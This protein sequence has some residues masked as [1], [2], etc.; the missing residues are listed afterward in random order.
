M[1][2]QHCCFL[3]VFV[4]SATVIRA[5]E[6]PSISAAELNEDVTI[7]VNALKEAHTGMYWYTPETVFNETEISIRQQI[8]ESNGQTALE[9]YNTIAPYV[10]LTKEDHCDISL[11]EETGSFLG[12][13]G[14]FFPFPVK[15]CGEK[16]YLIGTDIPETMPLNGYEL[17]AIDGNAMTGITAR[18]FTTFA[19][20]GNI[21]TSKY[22][23]LDDTGFSKL[24]AKTISWKPDHFDLLV[25][26]PGSEATQLVTVRS[27]TFAGLV[28]AFNTLENPLYAEKGPAEMTITPEYALLTIR[29]FSGSDYR[30][31]G[32]RF[33]GFIDSCFNALKKAGTQDLIIDVRAN[34][35][36][37]EGYEDYLFSYLATKPYNKYRYVETNALTYSFYE[38]TDY[39]DAK[40]RK[41]FERLLAK[42]FRYDARSGK[43]RRKKNIERPEP[44]RKHPF[45]GKLYI[46]AGGVTYSG[47]AEFSSLVRYNREAIFVG[48]EA[49]GGYYGNTSGYSMTLT[50]PHSKV[51]VE[52]PIVRF[53][54]DVSGQPEG[55]GALPDYPVQP[56]I[57]QFLQGIDTELTFTIGLI[58]GTKP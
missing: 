35:G 29:T 25:K 54:L 30:E 57:G 28:K 14:R 18:L 51:R 41:D 46:L 21:L 7:L 15:F 43:Y 26:E 24:Y 36:G 34:G 55:T 23:W 53:V 6:L 40:E 12:E 33:E 10:A 16:C 11:A 44:V 27:T 42:E 49:G 9:F 32:M 45:T 31:H 5:Q 13:H 4:L 50:L 2:T 17:L 20:D 1:K 58:N 48:E 22:R 38:Y 8:A 39:A 52:I 47:G 19:A 56:E 37:T 3:A